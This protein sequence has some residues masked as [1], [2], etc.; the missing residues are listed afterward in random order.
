MIPPKLVKITAHVSCSP[1]PKAVSLLQGVCQMMPK[2][3][4]KGTEFLTSS[5]I[6]F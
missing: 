4:M 3:V 5:Q 1:L 6:V 2:L